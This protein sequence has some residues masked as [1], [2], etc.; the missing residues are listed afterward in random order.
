MSR[1]LKLHHILLTLLTDQMSSYEQP[2]PPG[3]DVGKIRGKF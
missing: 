1:E 2:T 3:R